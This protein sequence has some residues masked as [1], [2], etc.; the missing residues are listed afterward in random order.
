MPTIAANI[1]NMRRC[2]IAI[3]VFLFLISL[4]LFRNC[5][6]ESLVY[7]NLKGWSTVDFRFSE[8]QRNNV[9]YALHGNFNFK[10]SEVKLPYSAYNLTKD[11]QQNLNRQLEEYGKWI[12]ISK[13]PDSILIEDP[14]AFFSGRYGVECGIADGYRVGTLWVLLSNDSTHIV[15]N[16]LSDYVSYE[17]QRDW[18]K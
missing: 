3:I 8:A 1:F 6:R 16:K 5:Q 13:N 11:F 14:K 18:L 2:V 12:I 4:V 17:T 10:H 15:L 9:N 7:R